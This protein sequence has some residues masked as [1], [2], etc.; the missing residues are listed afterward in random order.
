MACTER[1][2]WS[3][4]RTPPLVWF[5]LI[6]VMAVFNTKL[7]EEPSMVN[8]VSA[9]VRCAQRPGL[10]SAILL[11]RWRW[12][13]SRSSGSAWVATHDPWPHRIAGFG[14][15]RPRS[16]GRPDRNS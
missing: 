10:A 7:G 5:A 11:S 9:R 16:M 4:K 15:A 2:L 6:V 1:I 8:S 12:R 13:H 3:M 14:C